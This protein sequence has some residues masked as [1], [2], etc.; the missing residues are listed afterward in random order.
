MLYVDLFLPVFL[1]T[2]PSYSVC[3]CLV[4]PVSISLTPSFSLSL[5]VSVRWS[6]SMSLAHS[7]SHCVF[8]AVYLSFRVYMMS[9]SLTMSLS[10]FLSISVYTSVCLSLTMSL[11]LTLSICLLSSVFPIRSGRHLLFTTARP[12]KQDERLRRDSPLISWSRNHGNVATVTSAKEIIIDRVP[13][14]TTLT[15]GEGGV[16]DNALYRRVMPGCNGNR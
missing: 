11:C 4:P 6:L 13:A 1:F 9:S 5:C 8:L 16:G 10:L 3:L 14:E 2:P 15:R 7:I 12:G